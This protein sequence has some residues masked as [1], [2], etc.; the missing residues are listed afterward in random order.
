MFLTLWCIFENK[1]YTQNLWSQSSCRKAVVIMLQ[2]STK[3]YSQSVSQMLST[4]RS[5][6]PTWCGLTNYVPWNNAQESLSLSNYLWRWL[7]SAVVSLS[8]FRSFIEY[9]A[10]KMSDLLASLSRCVTIQCIYMIA[11]VPLKTSHINASNL[12]L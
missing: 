3:F 11:G 9:I 10:F 5:E 12:N 4:Y 6:T 2:S 7:P 1:K 8:L